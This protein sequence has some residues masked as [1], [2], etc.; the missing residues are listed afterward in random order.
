MKS[1][2]PIKQFTKVEAIRSADLMLSELNPLMEQLG[3]KISQK[4][5]TFNSNSF[6]ITFELSVKG[7]DGTPITNA[8]K[9]YERYSSMYGI[10]KK[11]NSNI[12]VSGRVFKITGLNLRSPKYPIIVTSGDKSYK[13]TIDVV[14][15]AKSV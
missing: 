7:E 14:N 4:R 2:K 8:A 10:N 3:V 5:G 6:T 15:S 13:L 11:L 9:D 1:I 12:E